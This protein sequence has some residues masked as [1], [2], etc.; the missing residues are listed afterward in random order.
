MSDARDFDGDIISKPEDDDSTPGSDTPDERD[1]EP[2]DED[3]DNIFG[4]GKNE[5]EDED[6]HDPS[7]AIVTGSIGDFVFDDL[8]GD[9]V[10]DPN[11]PGLEGVELILYKCDGTEVRRDTTDVN[12]AYLFDFLLPLME[13]YIVADLGNYAPEY[14][15]ADQNQGSNEELDSDVNLNGIGECIH[16]G[17]GEMYED[18][19]VGLV[20]L[21]SLGDFVWEDVN[22]NGQQDFGDSGIEDVIVVLIDN[23]G[24]EVARDT[25]DNQGMYLFEYV[26]PSDYKVEFILPG[27]YQITDP[28]VGNDN[29]DSDVT[30]SNGK[31]VTGTI[32]LSP[33]EDDL[34]VDA[35]LYI[36][37]KIGDFAWFDLNANGRQDGPENGINGLRVTLKDEN[38]YVV[39]SQKTRRDPSS[40][41]N[42]GYFKFCARPGSYYLVFQRPGHLASSEPFA[43]SDSEKDSDITNTVEFYSTY[44]VTVQSGDMRCDLDGGFHLKATMGDRVWHDQNG[45][46]I[47]DG[48]EP[49]IEGAIVQAYNSDGM[50]LDEDVSN[51]QGE[52]YIDGLSKGEY[53]LKVDPPS[54]YSFTLAD[55]GGDDGIDSDIDGSNGPRTTALY[56]VSPNEHEP[57]VDVGLVNG[58]L[59]VELIDFKAIYTG[60]KVEISWTTAM[61]INNDFYEVE[62]RHENEDS[63]I[64]IGNVRAS[65]TVYTTQDYVYEDHDVNRTGVYYYRLRQVDT[66][67]TE[68]RSEVRT[69]EVMG[70]GNGV[71]LY[72]N[73]ASNVINVEMRVGGVTG[74]E[75]RATIELI[76]PLGRSLPENTM[77]RD[78]STGTTV[79]EI[80][81]E[82]L[83]PG[84]YTVKIKIGDD[85][86]RI[87]FTKM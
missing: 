15:F 51:S 42:D 29:S 45:N 61:E 31:N 17:P 41:S 49:R 22:G 80:N 59:P 86:Q 40:G 30:R 5:N 4:D 66:D 6:D 64:V 75:S 48:G 9:G 72:P 83:A 71:D 50:M 34:S 57:D 37:A 54:G 58:F 23:N 39:S 65:G 13:Y 78:L 47:Q 19:D 74:D 2:G 70:A 26:R 79:E 36:C 53:Y 25:T 32:N 56:R 38:G 7:K 3:D 84:M 8:D 10:Q 68:A 62:K 11:E 14:G 20:K 52:F 69:V 60:E 33:G 63:Y 81:I 44:Y 27:D 85:I 12:G 16:I 35:G 67:G 82:N 77:S 87:R 28:N 24:N 76:D 55:Q 73:P 21:A 46:G 1:V 43:G 18:Y